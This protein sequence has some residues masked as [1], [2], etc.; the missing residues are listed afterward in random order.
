MNG[1]AGYSRPEVNG[2][3]NN[4]C[5]N[6]LPM[7]DANGDGIWEVTTDLP[8]GNY[9]FKFS[10]DNW[11]SSETLLEGSTCTITT[12]PFTNRRLTV[13]GTTVLPEVCWGTC[14][15]A[16]GGAG[17]TTTVA[18]ALTTGSNPACQSDEMIFTATVNQAPSTPVY[19]WKV[20]GVITGNNSPTFNSSVLTNGQIVTC[21][22]TCGCNQPTPVV[23][24]AIGIS[25]N[26]IV[27]P[28]VS[29]SRFPTGAVCQGDTVV[30]TAI[31]INGGTNPG[32][33]WKVNGVNTGN[34]APIFK[35]TTAPTPQ[36]FTCEMTSNAACINNEWRQTWSDEFTG[37]SLD[38]MKW[39]PQTGAGG[40]GNAEL[41]FYTN[42]PNNIQVSNDQLHIIARNTG[43]GAQQY[44]SARLFTKNKF[45]FKYGKIV[46]RIKVPLGQGI[47]PAFWMLGA[48]IDQV[49]WPRCGEI[50]VMEHVNNE[51][52]IHGTT[53]WHNGGHVYQGNTR[54]IDVNAYH[55]Y[56]VEW[57]SLRIRF[58]VDGNQYHEHAITAA[59]G[60]L[61]EF[62]KPFFIILNVAV[63]GNWP[64]FPNAGTPFPAT[65]SVDYVRVFTRNTPPFD[66][67]QSNGISVSP[68][69]LLTWYR[70]ADGDGFGD[71]GMSTTA[72]TQPTGYV[73]NNTDCN[74]NFVGSAPPAA[75]QI[76]GPAAVCGTEIHAF[77]VLPIAG[78]VA[79]RW[80]LP[81]E[82]SGASSADSITVSFNQDYQTS[83]ICVQGV[84]PCG[85]G[86]SFCRPVPVNCTTS[87]NDRQNASFSI[88]PNPGSG[89]FHL[90]VKGMREPVQF[91]VFNAWGQMVH[92]V[93]H[94]T[95]CTIPI[96][97]ESQPA[98]VYLVKMISGNS[99]RVLKL[100]KE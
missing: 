100:V 63:G 46:G 5:G 57:D 58:K 64:G 37:N 24:N 19:Q 88:F 34:N 70:D 56:S 17:S 96:N 11:N 35:T 21:E 7:S 90:Q 94:A 89:L 30:F 50:D 8:A 67:T 2:T 95:G 98:G 76:A 39:T 28:E 44:T 31:A 12:G 60:S 43:S 42:S 83:E 72:C 25:V 75:S 69:P 53:H 10:A 91:Q 1:I 73:S 6:C 93:L 71:P 9:E 99:Q 81:N 4:W 22:V 61:D 86:V 13:N 52:R 55:E 85:A 41:Q 14:S 15:P 68:L 16:D 97:L 3:F 59:N 32:F 74:D 62:T 33:Q 49:S 47:W 66:V 80:T 23:S 29:I 20:N 92:E 48:N 36:T 40:W 45:T 84:N 65:M 77:S 79:Y 54:N 87:L 38:N 18:I 82:A 26:P 27:V 51:T 78:A